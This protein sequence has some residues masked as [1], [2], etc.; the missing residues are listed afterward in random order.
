MR[1]LISLC[2][3]LALLVSVCAGC[4]ADTPQQPAAAAPASAGASAGASAAAPA[5]PYDPAAD[6]PYGVNTSTYLVNFVPTGTGY[7]MMIGPYLFYM[8]AGAMEP[9]PVCNRPNCLHYDEPD[10]KKE[11]TCGA[12]IASVPTPKLCLSW[13]DGKV[14]YIR[15]VETVNDPTYYW[16]DALVRTD[17]DGTNM[18]IVYRYD[19]AGSVGRFVLHRGVFYCTTEAIDQ[20]M[21]SETQLL[22]LDLREK[23]KEAECILTLRDPGVGTGLMAFTAYGD[24]LYWYRSA[25][26]EPRKFCIFDLS[27]RELQT[28]E[29]YDELYGPLNVTFIG[30]KMYLGAKSVIPLNGTEDFIA[31]PER[32]YRCDLDG[33][34]MELL[35]EGFGTYAS[36]QTYL[37][38][39]PSYGT[40]NEENHW[41]RILDA[42]AREVDRV[43]LYGIMDADDIRRVGVL[44]PADDQALL[45]ILSRD[46]RMYLYRFDKAE[47]GT[48]HIEL[49]PMLNYAFGYSSG[50]HGT[51]VVDFDTADMR[52]MAQ[53]ASATTMAATTAATAAT[54]TAAATTAGE[55]AATTAFVRPPATTAAV[56]PVDMG[57]FTNAAGVSTGS[58]QVE[59]LG[60]DLGGETVEYMNYYIWDDKKPEYI[61]PY[62][63]NVCAYIDRTYNGT[64]EMRFE[65]SQDYEGLLRVRIDAGMAPDVFRS[66]RLP[67]IYAGQTNYTDYD[68]LVR[69]GAL[70]A[71]DAY[72]DS[73]LA[74]TYA[75]TD[76]RLY[77]GLT[78]DGSLY[79]IIQYH[80]MFR[81]GWVYYDK[82]LTDAAGVEIGPWTH[83]SDLWEPMIA[84]RAWEDANMPERKGA[85]AAVLPIDWVLEGGFDTLSHHTQGCIGVQYAGC[86]VVAGKAAET[87]AFNLY[88]CPEFADY[89]KNV[90]QLVSDRVLR[91]GSE[92]YLYGR[93]MEDVCD[94]K[95]K[96]VLW[97]AK[98]D[99]VPPQELWSDPAWYRGTVDWVQAP[100]TVTLPN[101]V[102][103]IY[104]LTVVS[105]DTA[106]PEAACGFIEI[107][108]NDPY[109]GTTLRY[110]IEGKNWE[111]REDGHLNRDPSRENGAGSDY[112]LMTGLFDEIGD[113]TNALIPD[114]TPLNL[115]DILNDGHAKMLYSRNL[116]FAADLTALRA[117]YDAVN[118]V[119]DE[120]LTDQNL[121][122]GLLPPERIDAAV[123][124]FV[125]ALT[126]A[127]ADRLRAE[128]QRK[129]DSWRAGR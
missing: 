116:G 64:I 112:G 80:R 54:T 41:L 51:N 96:L 93:V 14:Y 87:E 35:W 115:A 30:D 29:P 60:I 103:S 120:Y 111:R 52:A 19:P 89:L 119:M 66:I 25:G 114:M 31:Y 65:S 113:I 108:N 110:G 98:N 33:S 106:A 48:G 81:D 127:G 37:Y 105:A 121:Y 43:D 101:T 26:D 4:G 97:Y 100:R 88:D 44:A 94:K 67:A 104:R 7:Y 74:R 68:T 69:E 27:T 118:A 78:V 10:P 85:A 23:R 58:I 76:R 95:V 20:E 16:Q 21:R 75:G 39:V 28:F 24:R 3:L 122:S 34:N 57:P 77:D 1:K 55:P 50:M 5:G 125:E 84:V 15:S 107:L 70:L 82:A 90:S 72:T 123:T 53:A 61:A 12:A 71:L 109:V 46:W 36:D 47:I 56:T 8:D 11:G 102:L 79:G 63:E 13:Y 2:L 91:E 92:N 126:A 42:D 49:Q 32:L 18:E 99:M 128:F 73:L 129:L 17:P 59:D 117:E 83:Y 62:W 6:W 124:A 9:V 45:W 22:A 86:E 40:V 38:Q